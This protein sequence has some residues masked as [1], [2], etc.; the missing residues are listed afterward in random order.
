MQ[1]K[2]LPAGE[3]PHGYAGPGEVYGGCL[4]RALGSEHLAGSSAAWG[5]RRELS[6]YFV[7]QCPIGQSGPSPQECMSTLMH[8]H[9]HAH[10]LTKK[11]ATW[12][13]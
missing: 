13:A 1:V 4:R 5:H 6:T 7:S 9:T 8:T 12:K 2:M 11:H 3:P 10:I